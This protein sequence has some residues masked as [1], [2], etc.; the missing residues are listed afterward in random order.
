MVQEKKKKSCHKT[1]TKVFCSKTIPSSSC[2]I[3]NSIFS[4]AL[5]MVH[6]VLVQFEQMLVF[7]TQRLSQH[8]KNLCNFVS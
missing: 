4:H 3:L 7:V 1:K 5:H 2:K 6:E 8:M